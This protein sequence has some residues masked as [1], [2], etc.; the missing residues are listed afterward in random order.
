MFR[1]R[2]LPNEVVNE[3]RWNQNVYSSSN[4][5]HKG[6]NFS[7][8]RKRSPLTVYLMTTKI[9]DSSYNKPSEGLRRNDNWW[10]IACWTIALIDNLIQRSFPFSELDAFY[11]KDE[12]S[13]CEKSWFTQQINVGCL[14]SPKNVLMELGRMTFGKVPRDWV[15]FFGFLQMQKKW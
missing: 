12:G 15:K 13:S 9:L 5:D 11:D 2:S 10:W 7:S 3:W 6:D 8:F 1:S 14:F 4:K